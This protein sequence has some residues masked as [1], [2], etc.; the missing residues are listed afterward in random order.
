MTLKTWFAAVTTAA[1]GVVC[2]QV[3]PTDGSGWSVDVAK[4]CRVFERT[5][6]DELESYLKL[7]VPSRQIS[8]D[9]CPSPVFHV[10]DTAFAAAKGLKSSEL[11]D[12]RW[13]VKSFGGDVVLIG[14]G[15]RGTLYAVSHFLEDELGVRWWCEDDADVPI[16]ERVVL[17]K[18]GLVGRPALRYRS[19]HR[20]AR[21][22]GFGPEFAVRRRLNGNGISDGIPVAWG[23]GYEYGPPDHAHTF[24]MYIPWRKYGKDHPEWFSLRDG[25]RI[26]GNG[27]GQLCLAN[28]DL[29]RS[30]VLQQLRANIA[31]GEAAAA[32]A[33]LASPRFY[34][35]SMNDNRNRYCTCERCQADYA[36]YGRSGQYIRFV[37]SIAEEIAADHPEIFI[38]TLA[39]HFTE[40]PPSGGVRAARN[41]I[42]RLCDTATNLAAPY[43]EPGNGGFAQLLSG[44]RGLAENLFVWDYAITYHRGTLGFPFASE[45]HCADAYRC[46]A[47]NG[48]SG[49][50]LEHEWPEL[51]DLNDIKFYLESRCMEDPSLDERALVKDAFARYFGKAARPAVQARRWIERAR[52]DSQGMVDWYCCGFTFLDDRD[53]AYV[54]ERWDEAERAVGSDAR[55]LAR[56]RKARAGSDRLYEFRRKSY[57]LRG[58]TIVMDADKIIHGARYGIRGT[59]LA[60]DSESPFGGKAVRHLIDSGNRD[61]MLSPFQM[62]IYDDVKSEVYARQVYPDRSKNRKY[63]WYELGRFRVRE[64]SSFFFTRAWIV[65]TCCGCPALTKGEYSLRALVKFTGPLF[66]PDS[67]ET[68]A[69]YLAGI[70]LTPTK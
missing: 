60:E 5:A 19:I 13:C 30:L 54:R 14:G 25:R 32:K 22:K 66:H 35:I 15:T 56:V 52:K 67:T 21:G 8:V 29:F 24:D 55:L 31:K 38:T 47:T 23:G 42:V 9:G 46:F 10:G 7:I 11:E 53:L 1:A 61:H 69:F 49:V 34:D 68:N 26:G 27:E 20:G 63:E 6:A 28:A 17:P 40:A 50:F 37:N 16:R 62:G 41:V 36:R 39:Y 51:S 2:A 65:Q 12:E 33:G 58:D 48:V 57:S 3:C 59:S 43:S 4:D 64:N 44:W 70:E 45:F 18:L